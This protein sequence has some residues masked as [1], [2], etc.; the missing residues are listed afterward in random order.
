MFFIL[1][2]K[3]LENCPC[4]EPKNWRSQSISL[5]NLEEVEINNFRGMD[6]EIDLVIM[7]LRRAPRLKTMTIKLAHEADVGC[8]AANIYDICL[9]YPLV[10]RS[11]YCHSGGLVQ[12]TCI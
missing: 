5:T 3:C 6:H 7:T 9:A 11:V 1:Q 12:H 8:C 10:N 4:D 2:L